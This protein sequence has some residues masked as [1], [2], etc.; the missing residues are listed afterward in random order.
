MWKSGQGAGV[1]TWSYMEL[2]GQQR[3]EFAETVWSYYARAG[4][5]ALPWRLPEA[6]GSFSPY[7]IVVSELMLQQ[8][9]VARVIP[10]YT[11]FIA[12]FPDT[13]T[14][15]Q[16]SLGDVLRAWQGLGYNRRAKYLWQ[17]AQMVD[18]LKY[19]PN[20]PK[21]LVKLPGVGP[22]TAG[23]ILAYAYGQPVI[24]V[25][26]NIRTVYIHHFFSGRT[27]VADKEIIALLDQTLDRENPRDFYWAL[28]DYGTHLKSTVGNL[29]KA[30]KHYTKQSRFHGSRR[31][32]RGQVIRLLGEHSL[33]LADLAAV[34]TDERLQSV[35]DELVSEGLVHQ[36]QTVYGLE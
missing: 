9:Q 23:A 19:F 27:D 5:S 32:V 16:A 26:T 22:N 6:D 33:P 12:R 31:A 3:A 4:R 24:F 7:K 29:S 14:L 8:T 21:E 25:E 20:T 34:I 15:A 35:L 11:A 36:D 30:S 13:Q 10:K 2:N 17:T 1:Y 28:M 18:D